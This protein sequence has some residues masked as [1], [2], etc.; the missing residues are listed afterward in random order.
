MST[1]IATASNAA[2]HA[3][4]LN[5]ADAK[6]RHDVDALVAAY[7]SEGRYEGSGIRGPI[8]GHARLREFYE[9]LF[10][11]IPDYQGRFAG[12]AFGDNTAVVWGH[13]TGTVGADLFGHPAAAGSRIDVPVTFVC[14]FREDGLLLSD[15]GYFDTHTLYEQAGVREFATTAEPERIQSFVAEWARFWSAPADAPNSVHALV[16]DDVVLNWPGTKEPLRGRNAYVA[17]L[18]AA[19]TRIPDLTL[20]VVD[21]AYRDGVLMLAWE[22]RGTIAGEERRWLGVDRFRIRA[23]QTAETTVIF[24]TRELFPD[25]AR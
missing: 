1:E 7:A 8:T 24:D 4:L 2:L 25:V 23:G 11:S 21:Y 10:A 17:Q 22:G 3:A 5:Y 16:T 12:T 15:C 18:T 20:S 14:K 13:M 9:A 6:N 19:V